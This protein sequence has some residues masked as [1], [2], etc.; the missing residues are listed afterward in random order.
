MRMRDEWEYEDGRAMVTNEDGVLDWRLDIEAD[1]DAS[2]INSETEVLA[3]RV[4]RL[5]EENE[6]LRKEAILLRSTL[7]D[8][9]AEVRHFARGERNA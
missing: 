9:E 4:L 7:N 3:A 5:A 1:P 2:G 6:R 8:V